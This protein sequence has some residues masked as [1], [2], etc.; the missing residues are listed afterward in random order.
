[1]SRRLRNLL[2]LTAVLGSV[3][4]LG[5]CS[6]T[7]YS[8]GSG[9]SDDLYGTHNRRALAE[10][11]RIEAEAAQAREEAR[12]ARIRAML[13]EAEA[14][15]LE[16]EYYDRSGNPYT[17]ILAD[18]Y[19]SAY[20][21][22]L[23]GFQSPT[24]KMPSSYYNY[25][26]GSNY[27]YASAYDPSFYNVIVMGDEV[28][29]EPKYITSMFG[30]WG[31]P[32]YNFS[33][34]WGTPYWGLGA[35]YYW[36]W[37]DYYWG[38]HYWG[39]SYNWSF[40]WGWYGYPYWGYWPHHHHNHYYGGRYRGDVVHRPSTPTWS[41]GYRNPSYVSSGSSS[42][43]RPIS[44]SSG[45]G[46]A[47]GG[48]SSSSSGGRGSAISS[49]STSGRGNSGGSYNSGSSGSSSSSGRGG[50][51]NSS[52]SSSGSSSRGGSYNSGSSNSSS[53]RGGNYSSGSSGSSGRGTRR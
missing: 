32:S 31:S 50:S 44:S 23:R 46:S 21:R 35:N 48:G 45:R 36:G 27:H 19:E 15:Q 28:W 8:S 14:N 18:D 25:R 51:Y 20:E 26:Y 33:F 52:S 4:I 11:E 29:V 1:M 24:Y 22:R 37:R 34:G 6:S 47:L 49:G 40:N 10:R 39:P 42:S 7:A 13:A 5:G 2:G 17:D 53:S 41:N 3:F 9:R 30:T 12:L 38:P 16:Y 43:G